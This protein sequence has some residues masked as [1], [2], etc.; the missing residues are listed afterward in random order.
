VACEQFQES[1][2]GL[3]Q[4]SGARVVRIACHPDYANVR[5]LQLGFMARILISILLTFIDGALQALNRFIV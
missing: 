3:W 1:R 4:L 2:F 5:R